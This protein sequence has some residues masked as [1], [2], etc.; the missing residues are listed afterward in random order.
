LL[1]ISARP[2]PGP[3]TDRWVQQHS[4]RLVSCLPA[5]GSDLKLLLKQLKLDLA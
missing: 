3:K 1:G 2:Q 4:A 5:T